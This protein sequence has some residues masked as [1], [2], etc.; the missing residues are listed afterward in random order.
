MKV[1]LATPTI[2]PEAG[3]PAFFVRDLAAALSERGHEIVVVTHVPEAA[4]VRQ[5][6][7][8]RIVSTVAPKGPFGWTKGLRQRLAE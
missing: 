3:G 4:A 8:F 7:A 5:D 2:A 1:V 6:G